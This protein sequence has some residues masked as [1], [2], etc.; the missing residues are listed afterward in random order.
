[1]IFIDTNIIIDAAWPLN[2]NNAACRYILA[3]NNVWIPEP[4][5]EE[6][7]Q[8]LPKLTEESSRKRAEMYNVIGIFNRQVRKN[9]EASL[10][11]PWKQIV[12][13]QSL[14]NGTA[15][16]LLIPQSRIQKV[17]PDALVWQAKFLAMTSRGREFGAGFDTS[18]TERP[19]LGFND[20]L[21]A[22]IVIA[23]WVQQRD[24][25][26]NGATL[27]SKNGDFKAIIDMLEQEKIKCVVH[28][29]DFA[30]SQGWIPQKDC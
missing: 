11:T 9:I 3:L 20:A 27:L 14:R 26:T 7:K 17:T 6:A 16:D 12:A 18:R 2:S 10:L 4:C 30:K 29:V 24:K 28:P 23:S 15:V 13:E 1:M 21:I 5:I 25:T 19:L 22:G 8:R